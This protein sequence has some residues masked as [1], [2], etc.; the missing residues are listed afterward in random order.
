MSVYNIHV[1]TR[2]YVY[3]PSYWNLSWIIQTSY[4]GVI[5]YVNMRIIC[6]DVYC[7]CT[8]TRR[9]T[10]GGRRHPN[11]VDCLHHAVNNGPRRSCVLTCTRTSRLT[12]DMWTT[13]GRLVR[14]P[15]FVDNVANYPIFKNISHK[16][17]IS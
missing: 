7:V 1:Y 8:Y 13:V 2:I 10:L 12:S 5:T 17:N 15:R 3:T 11:F 6:P 16:L 14:Y 9:T 4:Y